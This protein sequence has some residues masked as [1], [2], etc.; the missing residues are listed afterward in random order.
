MDIDTYRYLMSALT[1]VFGALIAIDAIFLI[2]QQQNILSLKSKLLFQ[3]GRYVTLILD[4][5]TIKID[6]MQTSRCEIDTDAALFE[7]K[8]PQ[9]IQNTIQETQTVIEHHFT[10]TTSSLQ[11]WK[12]KAE[13]NNSEQVLNQIRDLNAKLRDVTRIKSLFRDC[14]D[15]YF[16]V[17]QKKELLPSLLAATMFIPAVLVLIYSTALAQAGC[18]STKLT[19]IYAYTAI[20]ISLSAL[21][22][23]VRTALNVMTW[24]SNGKHENM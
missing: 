14:T 18:M 15:R 7:I 19:A 16:A 3:I 8:T 9:D 11:S 12:K 23:L 22:F 24:H 21:A 13:K 17:L 5:R 20:F 6:V 10:E 1:Q 2:F 4:F